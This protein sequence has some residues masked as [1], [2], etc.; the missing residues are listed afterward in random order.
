MAFNIQGAVQSLI[1]R[2]SA[3][4]KH[5]CAKYVR[6]AMDFSTGGLISVHR[7][8]FDGVFA[9]A[10]KMRDYDISCPEIDWILKRVKEFEPNLDFVRNPVTCGRITGYVW[11]YAFGN[12]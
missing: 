10:G 12:V 7:R 1:A 2:S 4:T 9:H 3:K 5:Q 8:V 6:M 11:Q